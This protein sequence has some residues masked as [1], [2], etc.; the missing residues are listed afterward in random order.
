MYQ[1][2][3]YY[4][5]RLMIFKYISGLQ[6]LPISFFKPSYTYYDSGVMFVLQISHRK[7]DEE[8]LMRAECKLPMQSWTQRALWA[9][10]CGTVPAGT[11]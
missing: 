10:M 5:L 3:N 11:L 1:V 4:K 6:Y 2:V 7:R 8:E 9:S